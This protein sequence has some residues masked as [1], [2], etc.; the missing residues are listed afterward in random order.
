MGIITQSPLQLKF[1]KS[2]RV[3]W[4]LEI[5]LFHLCE[6]FGILWDKRKSAKWF[7]S[8]FIQN[9]TVHLQPIASDALSC[10]EGSGG[11]DTSIFAPLPHKW[12]P[13]SGMWRLAVQV[14]DA[15][16]GDD[17]APMGLVC[18]SAIN[19]VRLDPRQHIQTFWKRQI[20]NGDTHNWIFQFGNEE[21][22]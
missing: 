9:Q 3:S 4:V 22:W 5:Q 15:P 6:P 14:L 1:G 7:W 21:M 2:K 10:L 17:T 8:D 20:F 19:R 11:E 16:S 18:L 13:R 12:P